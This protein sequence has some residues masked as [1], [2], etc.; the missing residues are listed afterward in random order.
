MSLES[1]GLVDGTVVLENHGFLFSVRHWTRVGLGSGDSLV[2]VRDG[3]FESCWEIGKVFGLWKA[4]DLTCNCI[5]LF[6]FVS[7]FSTLR[8]AHFQLIF[9]HVFILGPGHVISFP[10]VDDGFLMC[11]ILFFSS[12]SLT[13]GHRWIWLELVEMWSLW[14]FNLRF[15]N[16]VAF[17][18]GLL[19]STCQDLVGAGLQIW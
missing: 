2:V 4:P 10:L 7:L 6:D 8:M 1:L 18:N 13:F 19:V 5:E 9:S 3:T 14:L 17:G 16:L 15:F 12:K 11:I